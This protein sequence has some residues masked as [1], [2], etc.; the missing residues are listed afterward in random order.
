LHDRIDL[1]GNGRR[2]TATDALL[3]QLR[4]VPFP[5]DPKVARPRLKPIHRGGD[6][7]RGPLGRPALADAP[8]L[9]PALD[10]L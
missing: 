8:D 5:D 10:G 2:T 1:D 6:V 4:L 3:Q 7:A 9:G